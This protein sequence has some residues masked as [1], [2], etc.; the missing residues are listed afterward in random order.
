VTRAQPNGPDTYN[1][2]PLAVTDG[3][4]IYGFPPIVYDLMMTSVTAT[5][6][7]GGGDDQM[8]GTLLVW[9]WG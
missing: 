2:I 9:F 6:M 4:I 8:T 7:C 5:L 3:A 1:N